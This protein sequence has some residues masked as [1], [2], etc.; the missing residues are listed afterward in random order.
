MK[1]FWI[2]LV[3]YGLFSVFET[4]QFK[5]CPG[6]TH[7]YASG[8]NASEAYR[9]L[10]ER[11]NKSCTF[12]ASNLEIVNLNF[13]NAETVVDLSFLETIEQ[14]EGFV[15][16]FGNSVDIPLKNLRVIH[17]KQ[18]FDNGNYSLYMTYNKRNNTPVE[19]DLSSLRDVVRGQVNIF[20]GVPD[21]LHT[22]NWSEICPAG[23]EFIPE[24][25]TYD[26]ICNETCF[27]N[28]T[29]KRHC[30]SENNCQKMFKTECQN[31]STSCF[32]GSCCAEQCVG[33][34][35]GK[36]NKN[37]FACKIMDND[38]KCVKECPKDFEY[39]PD[40][41]TEVY[42]EKKFSSGFKCV[43]KC[44][45]TLYVTNHSC[46][47]SCGNG[48]TPSTNDMTCVPCVDCPKKC[49]G[50]RIRKDNLKDFAGCE[51]IEGGLTIARISDCPTEQELSILKSVKEIRDYLLI[52]GQFENLSFMKNLR[53][54]VGQNLHIYKEIPLS[55]FISKTN[56][57]S[58][59]LDSLETI[60]NGEFLISD[61]FLLEELGFSHK[62]TFGGRL[63]I[64]NNPRLCFVSEINL[65][66][67][68]PKWY[69]AKNANET[70]CIETN[71]TCS[72]QCENG[73][74]G[75]SN[76]CVRC[77]GISFQNRCLSCHDRPGF[78][79]NASECH[80]C[81]PQCV[82]CDGPKDTDCIGSCRN[83]KF[84]NKC[85]ETCP[86]N[87]FVDGKRICQP[88]DKRCDGGCF[89]PSWFNGTDG[90]KKC[91]K[92]FRNFECMNENDTCKQR[93]YFLMRNINGQFCVKNC[94]V[95]VFSD[96]IDNV[97]GVS[98]EN[99]NLLMVSLFIFCGGAITIIIIGSFI[100]CK[101]LMDK[102]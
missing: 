5:S 60:A 72:P 87:T 20:N 64:I 9:D 10:V 71:K 17:G 65:T 31:C 27:N 1:V 36:G 25:L 41:K 53:R 82:N 11:Y 79:G 56:V 74:W 19:I 99:E 67:V 81:H 73:C 100:A 50:G 75:P 89:G 54:V 70:W 84:G 51:I 12:I 80:E 47:A 95:Q 45:P 37:C 62:M 69:L 91:K 78:F 16:I 85:V 18:K 97:C 30:W 59:K 83:V 29:G 22:I 86:A 28:S 35:F 24:N 42:P 15:M 101:R 38:G 7:L 39:D 57:S 58:L 32:N 61:N 88:C 21:F 33:G 2:N 52:Q 55:M 90:C 96:G 44:E 63:S 14:V 46:V 34:C 94:P 3:F 68:A 26:S 43:S 98:L 23:R 6:T 48:F 76:A 92:Y 93:N 102:K 8:K 77:D 13:K 40:T 66:A 49:P 4:R